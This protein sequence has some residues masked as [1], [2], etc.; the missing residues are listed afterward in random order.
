MS[1]NALILEQEA[2][3]APHRAPLQPVPRAGEYSD[4]IRRLVRSHSVLAI[5]GVGPASRA[6]EA[7]RGVAVEL[8]ASG[9]RIVIVQVDD[10]LRASPVPAATACLPGSVPNVWFWPSTAGPS[11]EFFP[12]PVAPP[13]ES[14]W[15]A[16]LRRDF[17]SVLLDCSVPE[18]AP[19]AAEIAAM[20]DAAVL[21]VESGQ[22]HKQHIQRDQRALQLRGVKLAGC[23][24][25]QQR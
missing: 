14:D 10:L 16:D 11:I 15:L 5:I 4:L 13:A 8:A 7:C 20:A 19:G 9:N 12:S 24:L 18:T 1:R 2:S 25:M 17:D 23:I 21:V 3:H 6:A 22:T